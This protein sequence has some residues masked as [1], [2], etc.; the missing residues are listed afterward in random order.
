M[1]SFKCNF[2]KKEFDALDNQEGFGF[3]Y[4]RIGY[5][6]KFDGGSIDIDLCCDCF[7]KMMD[8]YVMPRDKFATKEDTTEEWYK[9]G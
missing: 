8:E 6:S 9:Y 7:D 2:C 3:H 4:P 5:G 1:K